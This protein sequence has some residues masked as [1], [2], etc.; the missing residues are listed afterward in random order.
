[1]SS[2]NSSFIAIPPI[3]PLDPSTTPSERTNEEAQSKIWN[4][5]CQEIGLIDFLCVFVS[6][7]H[8]SATLRKETGREL[9]KVGERKRG[10]QRSSCGTA[11]KPWV[12]SAETS[13]LEP[14]HLH[15]L[16]RENTCNV[17]YCTVQRSAC[18]PVC[19]PY[20][21]NIWQRSK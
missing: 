7:A 8:L 6:P 11:T 12:V 19:L 14:I 18:L 21:G 9:E 3:V 20:C 16:I 10:H 4:S 17:L 13:C 2:N 1:M 15:R 5:F